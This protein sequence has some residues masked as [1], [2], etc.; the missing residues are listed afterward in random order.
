[1]ARMARLV[2]R[3]LPHHVTQRGVRSVDIFDDDEDRGGEPRRA[4]DAGDGA[5][6]C[7]G[8]ARRA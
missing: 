4:A 7:R 3:G 8:N 6:R 2:V 5:G 1:M